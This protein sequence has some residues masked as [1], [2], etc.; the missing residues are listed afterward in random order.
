MSSNRRSSG[1]KTTTATRHHV[2]VNND[3]CH[4]YGTCQ[5]EAPDLFQLTAVGL[6]YRKTVGP[7]ELDQAKAAVRCCP[8][9][10]ITLEK[11]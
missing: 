11:S 6:R 5:Y 2:S 7:K 9:M 4:R 10:A 1:S 8:M 3:R